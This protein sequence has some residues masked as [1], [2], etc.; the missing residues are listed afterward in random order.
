MFFSFSR[1]WVLFAALTHR[2]PV[3]CRVGILGAE[4]ASGHGAGQ[5]GGADG[6]VLSQRP[7]QPVPRVGGSPVRQAAV[8]QETGQC[9]G[10]C[11]NGAAGKN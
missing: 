9:D 10:F 2:A 5:A 7:A 8:E 1:H 11:I 6:R 3:S 4:A